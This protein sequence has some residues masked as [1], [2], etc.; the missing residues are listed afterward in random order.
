LSGRVPSG[1]AP[2]TA[3]RSPPSQASLSGDSR[4]ASPPEDV[5]IR[6]L[7]IV[8]APEIDDGIDVYANRVRIDH[9][10]IEG[11]PFD[12][13]Y[14]GGRTNV[15]D[16]SRDV[17]L[18]DSRLDGAERNGVSVTAAV[19]VRITGN[20]IAGAGLTTG[21][22]ADPGDGIDV[23]PNAPTDPIAGMLIASNLIVDSVG[24]GIALALHPH[25]GVPRR[26]DRITIVG[27]RIVGNSSWRRQSALALAG[28]QADGRGHVIIVDNAFRANGGPPLSG[29]GATAF[30]LT[31]RDNL[32]FPAFMDRV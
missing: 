10:E 23:E 15:I 22:A 32:E 8:V 20:V 25:G 19:D 29:T 31:L 5:T 16:Y 26:A 28:G 6:G 7:R 9:V 17:V 18:D 24:S 3:I 11:A 12:D 14:I 13:V 2:Q 30:E 1:F 4:R 27:N 21:I